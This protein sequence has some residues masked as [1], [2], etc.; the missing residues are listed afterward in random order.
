MLDSEKK[1]EYYLILLQIIW[2]LKLL[3]ELQ[4]FWEELRNRI[5]FLVSWLKGGIQVNVH[6]KNEV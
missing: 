5:L 2:K 1:V 3:K 6:T 4:F